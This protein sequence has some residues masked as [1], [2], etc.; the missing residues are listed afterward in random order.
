MLVQNSMFDMSLHVL[1]PGWLSPSQAGANAPLSC[2]PLCSCYAL[3]PAKRFSTIIQ[4]SLLPQGTLIRG[5]ETSSPCRCLG[6]LS[7]SMCSCSPA[8]ILPFLTIYLHPHPQTGAKV[9]MH[10][11][12]TAES[13]TLRMF[14][15][16]SVGGPDTICETHLM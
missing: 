1:K 7:V 15:G 6:L 16:S 13:R 11:C 2:K 3:Q 4:A 12:E 8:F 14:G 5:W 9:F 10:N